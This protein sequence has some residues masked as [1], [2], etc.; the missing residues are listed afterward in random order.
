[1][2]AWLVG[3]AMRCSFEALAF[4]RGAASVAALGIAAAGRAPT[5]MSHFCSSV[6]SALASRA[7][8]ASLL[9]SPT[10][11]AVAGWAVASMRTV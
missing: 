11:A 9:V 2:A 8:T 7:S 4:G 1:M 10:L 3:A 6:S 5:M